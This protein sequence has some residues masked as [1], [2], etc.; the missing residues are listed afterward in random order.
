[1]NSSGTGPGIESELI[2]LDGVPFTKLR[3]LGDEPLRR[4]MQRVVERTRHL[5]TTYRSSNP[6]GGER[7]D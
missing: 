7:V 3:E 5:R 6:S 2:D 1:M 4:S